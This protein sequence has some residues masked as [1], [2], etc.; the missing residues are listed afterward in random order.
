[1]I[2]CRTCQSPLTEENTYRN[3]EKNY[4]YECKFCK[5]ERDRRNRKNR[6][7]GWLEYRR[8][9]NKTRSTEKRDYH[10]KKTYG[11][12]LVQWEDIFKRQ[13]CKCKICQ[14]GEEP[15]MGW[16]TD[17]DHKTGKVRGILCHSCNTGLGKFKDDTEI[18][19]A[20][21]SYLKEDLV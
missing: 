17:H 8:E 19:E 12:T 2:F 13:G 18:L 16:H 21:I 1:M 11:L 5:R 3:Y 7:E 15:S 20:A 9:Y 6:G 14:T 4:N 10:L